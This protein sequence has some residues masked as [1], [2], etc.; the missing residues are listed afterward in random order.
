MGFIKAAL[1]AVVFFQDAAERARLDPAVLQQAGEAAPRH[2]LYHRRVVWISIITG[3]ICGGIGIF[4]MFQDGGVKHREGALPLYAP[5]FFVI[6]G[7][8]LGTAGACLFAPREFLL[9]PIGA[10]WME[11][12][13]A[14]NPASAR[15]VC[16]VVVFFVGALFL[17]MA[18]AHTLQ[19]H[20]ILPPPRR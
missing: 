15:F 4:G 6:M 16:A 18:L 10:R 9:G 13:G 1:K 11:L 12:I 2:R 5:V 17:F 8:L 14:K 20:G 19:A 7:M 3:L